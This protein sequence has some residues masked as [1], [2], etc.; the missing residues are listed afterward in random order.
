[1][2]QISISYL[3]SYLYCPI[4][5]YIEECLKIKKL[6]QKIVIK[7]TLKHK[8]I[9]QITKKEKAFVESID[10]IKDYESLVQYYKMNFSSNVRNVLLKN[11]FELE[12]LNLPL[13]VLFQEFKPV[14]DF[15]AMQRAKNIFEQ[16][17]KTNLTGKELWYNLNPKYIS[18]KSLK[19]KEFGLCG[20]IDRL[21]LWHDKIVP[22]EFKNRE[23]STLFDSQKIQLGSYILLSNKL[24]EK[25][26]TYGYVHFLKDNQKKLL[27]MNEFLQD[28][29]MEVRSRVVDI[30][31]DK[32][33][34][35]IHSIKV[36]PN[37]CKICPYQAN[38]KQLKERF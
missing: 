27:M 37:K 35:N 21:E 6:D 19:S 29:I 31:E 18:E 10:K 22:I 7:G 24:Y 11:K 8:A 16:H 30:I 4:K 1:M 12:E 13:P 5:F 2:K 17:K 9:E 36:S 38:C 32:K 28:E 33:I 3:S 25:P 20:R 34:P 14:F 15:E 23:S 26:S